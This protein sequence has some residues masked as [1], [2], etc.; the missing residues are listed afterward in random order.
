MIYH[1]RYVYIVY[2]L[3]I[4]GQP[5]LP[6]CVQQRVTSTSHKCDERKTVARLVSCSRLLQPTSVCLMPP[7][8]PESAR[9]HS[10]DISPWIPLSMV[11]S[12]SAARIHSFIFP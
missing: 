7:P 3:K 6:F 10:K 9:E 1:G 2:E 12:H 5:I 8:E 11:S 4:Q